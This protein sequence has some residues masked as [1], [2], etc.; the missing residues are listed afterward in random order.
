MWPGL[1]GHRA[2]V[3]IPI[4][5]VAPPR[6]ERDGGT[7][8][9]KD[10]EGE[11]EEHRE[12]GA[13]PGARD[14]VRVVLEYARAVVT[15]V[16]LDEE[17]GDELA[18]DDA[19]LACVVGNVAGVLNQLG[20]VDLVEREALDLGDELEGVKTKEVSSMLCV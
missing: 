20:H 17:A 13:V 4:D 18:E 5:V 14:Q 16:E 10:G 12:T 1:L 19:G 11:D 9:A 3:I 15:E 7:A 2:P 6:R 8:R